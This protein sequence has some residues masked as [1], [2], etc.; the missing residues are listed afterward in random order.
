MS[1]NINVLGVT[2]FTPP[3]QLHDLE[4]VLAPGPLFIKWYPRKILGWEDPLEKDMATHSSILG[5]ENPMDRGAWRATVY[6]AA[7]SWT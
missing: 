1:R 4:D 6:R 7:K 5:L 3:V 2:Q